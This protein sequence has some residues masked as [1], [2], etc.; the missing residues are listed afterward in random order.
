MP[1]KNLKV[2]E[3]IDISSLS[4]DFS[5]YSTTFG[6]IWVSFEIY[7]IIYITIYIYEDH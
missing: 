7:L 4:M 5:A 3:G 6:F 2:N 1:T